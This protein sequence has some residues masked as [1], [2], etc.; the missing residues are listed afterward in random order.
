MTSEGF[1]RTGDVGLVDTDPR[2]L[3]RAERYGMKGP[4]TLADNGDSSLFRTFP[5]HTIIFSNSAFPSTPK[6][7]FLNWV[8][9]GK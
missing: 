9:K 4:R 8:D 1:D 5:V 6:W 2:R 7:T 3:V